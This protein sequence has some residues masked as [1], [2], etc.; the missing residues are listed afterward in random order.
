MDHAGAENARYR[1]QTD[2]IRGEQRE[3]DFAAVGCREL[4]ISSDLI[5]R[6]RDES[7]DVAG[8]FGFGYVP[9][10]VS[11]GDPRNALLNAIQP[12]FRM[13]T[14]RVLRNAEV[15]LRMVTIMSRPGLALQ[16]LLDPVTLGL[17]LADRLTLG[18]A[19]RLTNDASAEH[20][21]Q[22]FLPNTRSGCAIRCSERERPGNRHPIG[23]IP[24]RSRHGLKAGFK[25]GLEKG[26][27]A[28]EAVA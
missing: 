7:Q 3:P 27:L 23:L 16:A 2:C 6:N 11:G 18:L 28:R 21:E 10:N 22:H 4:A 8:E 9:M 12:G 15:R 19:S 17:N 5:V 20:V 14:L 24:R 13:Q 26:P 25:G 1:S